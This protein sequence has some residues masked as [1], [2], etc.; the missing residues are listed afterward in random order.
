MLLSLE[1]RTG[2]EFTG[3]NYNYNSRFIRSSKIIRCIFPNA[4]K[5]FIELTVD[6]LSIP[7]APPLLSRRISQDPLEKFF[8]LQR[9]R[10]RTN[11]NPNSQQ[12]L[13]NTQGLVVASQSAK[14]V[15]GNCR[16]NKDMEEDCS[17]PL[18]KRKRSRS[19]QPS[20]SNAVEE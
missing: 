11:E 13:K 14:F 18:P 4:V 6:V 8:G 20:H 12:F 2:L 7:G 15:K 19:T 9:Q 16:G 1:T 5:A 3:K 10:G 17:A